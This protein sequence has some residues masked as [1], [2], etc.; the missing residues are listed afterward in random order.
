MRIQFSADD[1]KLD[2]SMASGGKFQPVLST[3]R[4]GT[5]LIE[6]TRSE[7]QGVLMAFAQAAADEQKAKIESADLVLAQAGDRSVLATLRVKAKKMMVGVG[8]T[9]EGRADFDERL[10]VTL[11]GLKANGDGMVGSMV[12]GLLGSKLKQHEGRTVDL[13]PPALRNVR[14]RDLK[15]DASDPLRLTAAFES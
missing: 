14:L 1:V 10:G 11:S 6:I 8:V 5:V 2:V 3:A 15:V 12:A 4:N 9:V 13:A 7:L